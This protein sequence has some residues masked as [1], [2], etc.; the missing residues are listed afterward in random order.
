MKVWTYPAIILFAAAA[1]HAAVPVEGLT[2]EK[3]GI[4]AEDFI[5]PETAVKIALSH[6]P[7]YGRYE[8]IT[9][10]TFPYLVETFDN[11]G[12]PMYCYEITAVAGAY[13]GLSCDDLYPHLKVAEADV[14]LDAEAGTWSLSAEAAAR[15]ERGPDEFGYGAGD[16]WLIPANLR[17]GS[18]YILG[19]G[20][21]GSYT[22]YRGAATTVAKII[23]GRDDLLPTPYI[24]DTGEFF[25]F[26]TGDETLAVQI[27][28][29]RP[30]ETPKRYFET[31]EEFLAYLE[32][33]LR[34]EPI[35]EL[36]LSE[37]RAQVERINGEIPDGNPVVLEP[38]EE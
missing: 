17:V 35:E 30:R 12:F 31:R 26:E 32:P 38:T 9:A 29:R 15:L 22:R 37:V 4:P 36:D 24:Q 6:S 11:L 33:Y 2:A 34:R 18:P 1:A 28:V 10:V 8:A 13:P 21:V 27:T 7:L 5:T 25:L 16:A 3:V 23:T 20:S 14:T 19:S